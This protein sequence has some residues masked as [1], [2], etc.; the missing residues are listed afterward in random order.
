MKE[1]YQILIEDETKYL[2]NNINSYTLSNLNEEE[3]LKAKENGFILIGKTGT[4]KISLLNALFG[5]YI[6]KVVIHQ[7]QK[8]K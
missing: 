3:I 6:G 7:N 2:N 5:D 4:G 8:Q 1:N